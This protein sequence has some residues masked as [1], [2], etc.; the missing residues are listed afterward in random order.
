M[1]ID[2]KIL[3]FKQAKWENRILVFDERWQTLNSV[4]KKA[5][6][7]TDRDLRIIESSDVYRNIGVF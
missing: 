3:D 7:F 5:G 2:E 4:K 6:D 1:I